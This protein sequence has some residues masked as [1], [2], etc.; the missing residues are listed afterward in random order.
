MV[1]GTKSRHERGYGSAWVKLR[2][3]IMERDCGLCQCDQCKGGAI[4]VTLAQEVDHITPKAQGG[5]DDPTNLRA[6]STEC[7]KRIT[8]EQMG[9]RKRP[10][11]VISEDGWPV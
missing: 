6:V 10:R 7:H 1:W 4:K 8:A 5:T 3:Q 11:K 2:R 9:K